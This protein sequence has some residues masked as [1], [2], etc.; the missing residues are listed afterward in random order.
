MSKVNEGERDCLTLK[1]IHAEELGM[2]VTFGAFCSRHGLHYS[3]AG[4]TLLGAVRHGGFIPWDD[5]V[6]VCMA[7][8]DWDRLVALRNELEDEVGFAIVPYKGTD[9]DSTP[10][11]KIVNRAIA[12]QA[13]AEEGES[14][15]W[16]DVFPVD[17]LPVGEPEV[18]DIYRHAARARTAL[19][20]ATS[21]AGSGHSALRRAAKALVGPVLRRARAEGPLGARLDRIGR[22]TAYGSTP[23]VGAVTWGLYG[24][25]ER[26]PLEGFEAQ[27]SVMFEGHEMPCMSCWRDYLTGIYGDYM[28]LPPVEKRVTH[29]LKA[30]RVDGG[31]R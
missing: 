3:L 9:V 10:F 23:Y 31:S 25:G 1:E 11:V 26:M 16:L 24:P 8:P 7:R 13:E 15:L 28:Q 6:D 27:A 29:G 22:A 14:F 2:L 17:G 5:D 30:W 18:K 4:G 12:V 20:V 21:T 19:F